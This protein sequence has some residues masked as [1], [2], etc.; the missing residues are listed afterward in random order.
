MHEMLITN[1]KIVTPDGLVQQDILV[2][3][4]IVAAIGA[5][6]HTVGETIDCGGSLVGPG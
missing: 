3:D 1:G 2:K 6:L 5:N 4:G